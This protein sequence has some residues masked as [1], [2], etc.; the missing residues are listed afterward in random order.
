MIKK[1]LLFAF[2]FLLILS[3]AFAIDPSAI[4]FAS[5]SELEMMCRMR[6]LETGSADEMRKR[7]YEYENVEAYVVK[8]KTESSYT[9]SIL[10]AEVVE[11][12]DDYVLIAGNAAISLKTEGGAGEK[13]IKAGKIILDS[14]NKQ[15]TALENVTFSDSDKNASI[16][17]ITADIISVLWESEAFYITDATTSSERKNSEDEAVTFYTSGEKL[18]YFPDGG[19]LYENGF[20]SSD[21]VNRYSSIDADKIAMLPGGDMFISNAFL[22]IGRV[23]VLYIPFFFFPGSRILG[24]PSFGF[25]STKGAFLNTTFELFGSSPEIAESSDS[26]SFSAILRPTTDTGTEIVKGFYYTEADELSNIERWAMDS[27]SY[28]SILA[29]AYS[30]VDNV[31]RLSSGMLHLGVDGKINL[32]DKKLKISIS[33]GVGV[34]NAVYPKI[35]DSILRYYGNNTLSFSGYGLSVNGSFPFYSDNYVLLDMKNRLAGFSLDPILGTNPEFPDTYSTLSSFSRSLDL[36]YRLPGKYTNKYLSSLSLSSLR[37]K[38]AYSWLSETSSYENRG[39]FN[40]DKIEKPYLSASISGAI[41]DYE[42]EFVVREDIEDGSVDVTEAHLL[43]DEL[44]APLYSFSSKSGRSSSGDKLSTSLKYT[45]SETLGYVDDYS[46]G[47]LK[48]SEFSSSTSAKFTLSGKF[49]KWFS[50]SNTITPTYTYEYEESYSDDKTAVSESDTLSLSNTLSAS[51][52]FLGLSYTLSTKLMNTKNSSS[53]TEGNMDSLKEES[54]VFHP[55]WDKNTVT[56]HQ[57]AFSKS[58]ETDAGTF[59]PSISYTL[60]PLTGAIQPKFGYRYGPFTTALSW[61]FLEDE[62]NEYKS[63]L[64]EYSLGYNGTYFVF[65]SQMKYQS[66]DYRSDDFFYPFSL[67]SSAS[68]RSRNKKW[69]IVEYV[70]YEVFDQSTNN[71]NY[72]NSIK[73]TLNVPY[74]SLA[75]NWKSQSD[76]RVEFNDILFRI[77][78]TSSP[79]QFWKGR[80]YLKLGLD[81]S[82]SMNMFNKS[83][84]TFTFSPSITFSI[85]EFLDFKFSVNSYNNNFSSY[86]DSDKFRFDWMFSDLMRSFDFFSDGRENTNFLMKGLSLDVVHYMKDWDL[87]CKYSTEFVQSGNIYSLMPKFSIYLSWKTLPDLKVDQKWKQVRSVQGNEW[88][89]E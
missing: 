28:L 12:K 2:L 84:A 27:E 3:G 31:S 51:L 24:N 8:D 80:I 70:D 42:G 73:T 52:D 7:L 22:S 37:L 29:D 35:N 44:L 49:G 10:S 55:G 89:Q 72:F 58:F 78:Y 46:Y 18:S 50:L 69:S 87:H 71:R 79:F 33:D 5:Q 62:P 74:A 25:D 17:E 88:V 14:A 1:S 81:S 54:S 20:I 41:F 57:I 64:I 15:I 53:W 76:G 60:K 56:Q 32:L 86:F 38:S 11:K 45:L 59:S 40:I 4:Y 63:D 21:S 39:K 48:S 16:N 23:P 13:T 82:F 66:K 67:T 47:I 19:I 65:S 77:S 68:I 83:A 43:S 6:S 9:L 26:S 36:S 30:G 34:S 61:K 85:A 75:L